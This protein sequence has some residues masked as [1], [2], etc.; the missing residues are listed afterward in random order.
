MGSTLR[1]AFGNTLK[2]LY[3]DHPDRRVRNLY[4]FIFRN[5]TVP[6][7]KDELGVFALKGNYPNPYLLEVVSSRKNGLKKDEVLEF[8]ITLF[9]SACRYID[10]VVLTIEKMFTG[11]IGG[12]IGIFHLETVEEIFSGK[13]LSPEKQFAPDDELYI[14]RSDIRFDEDI[15]RLTISFL[16]EISFNVECI[17]EDGLS[18]QGFIRAIDSRISLLCNGYSNGAPDLAFRRDLIERA[19]DVQAIGHTLEHAGFSY[20]SRAQK[21]HG[22]NTSKNVP[23]SGFIGTI[24]YEGDISPFLNYIIAGTWLHIGAQTARGLGLYT[25][26]IDTRNI[27]DPYLLQMFEK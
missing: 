11:R 9:G 19:K 8:N 15:R 6:G 22:K 13:T 18:F 24:E 17:S 10:E 14:W 26:G 3:D 5:D 21:S 27:T 25:W 12:E 23:I 7:Y 4:E 20:H 1:G 16:E 2:W